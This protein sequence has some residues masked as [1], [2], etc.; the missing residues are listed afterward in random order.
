MTDLYAG[1]DDGG[2]RADTWLAAAFPNVRKAVVRKMLDDGMLT[3]IM[4]GRKVAKGDRI[5]AGCSYRLRCLPGP[6]RL[7]PNP[8]IP[9]DLIAEDD[10]L[11]AVCKQAGTNCLP[12][13]V[14]ETDTLANALL[15]VRPELEG[16]GDSSLTCGVLHRIDR[17]TS[18]L[19]L[20]AADQD[21]YEAVRK[22]FSAH[23]VVKHY[24]AL[25]QGSVTAPGSL[26][27]ELAHNPRCP[28]RMI[29]ATK[30]NGIRRPMHAET[31]YAP[32]GRYRFQNRVFSLLDVTIRTGV[33]HQIRAQFSFAG[34]PILGDRRYGGFLIPEFPRHFLHSSSADI[35]HPRTG[36]QVHYSAPLTA[37]LT[38]LLRQ[39]S[40]YLP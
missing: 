12:N 9:F 29:D 19:V 30:W 39:M 14:G 32:I 27:N 1:P 25:V 23:T 18:G 6:E 37:D 10:G 17:D 13:A 36:Q 33:T 4:Q 2:L 16:V 11:L 21:L 35:V 20:V 15:A 34:M 28:G 31:V 22:Q 26:V 7:R 5:V 40:P 24:T 38:E 8:R 3:E